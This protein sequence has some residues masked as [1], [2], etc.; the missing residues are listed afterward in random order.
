MADI[1]EEVIADVYQKYS[2][3]PFERLR[4]EA[5]YEGSKQILFRLNRYIREPVKFKKHSHRAIEELSNYLNRFYH[6]DTLFIDRLMYES[7]AYVLEIGD[8]G[9]P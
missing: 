5:L 9:G 7:R 1:N 2:E 4:N 6:D 3:A 8:Y